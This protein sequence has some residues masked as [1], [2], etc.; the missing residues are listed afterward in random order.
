V[1]TR[2]AVKGRRQ[3][4][5]LVAAVL[6]GFGS[7]FVPTSPAVAAACDFDNATGVLSVTGPFTELIR[8]RRS[9]DDM[10]LNGSVCTGATVTT[11]ET[12]EVVGDPAAGESLEV[13]LEGGELAPGRTDEGDGSSEIEIVS[14]DVDELLLRGSSEADAFV[15]SGP[16]V[17][18]N[19]DELAPDEDVTFEAP[20]PFSQILVHAL[21]GDDRI[22]FDGG[23]SGPSAFGNAFVWG[24]L[25]NDTLVPASGSGDEQYWAGW[26]RDV[27]DYSQATIGLNAFWEPNGG[28][29]VSGDG[30]VDTF[31]SVRELRLGSG[32]DS[33]F[34]YGDVPGDVHAGPGDDDI[35][36][37]AFALDLSLRHSVRGGL[38]PD[39]LRVDFD[40]D[41]AVGL[42]VDLDRSTIRGGWNGDYA[43]FASIQT[44]DAQDRFIARRRGGYPTFSGGGHVDELWLR[45][46]PQRMFVALT[47]APDDERTWLVAPEIERVVGSPFDD[48]L[49]GDDTIWNWLYGRG[50]DDVL[51]GKANFDDLFGGYGDDILRGGPGEFDTCRGGP[52]IDR[53]FGCER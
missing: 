47:A 44:G 36:F 50:G 49:V 40:N 17:N 12:I 43:G 11:T 18:L 15:V 10:T 14:Q 32:D 21:S 7:L 48:V 27:V 4:R 13:S 1:P 29:E 52:G 34:Q 30:G 24:G 23:T 35:A 5:S 46:A 6:I 37:T 53:L 19:A 3:A 45:E 8:I 42:T 25:G 38:G 9:G 31:S 22:A 28:L 33:F 16:S 2:C 26:G 39:E 51:V 20:H 41:D